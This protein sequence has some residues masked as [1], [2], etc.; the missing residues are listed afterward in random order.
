MSAIASNRNRNKSDQALIKYRE[1]FIKRQ[2]IIY[3]SSVMLSTE[4]SN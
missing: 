4:I 1:L 2:I 3:G